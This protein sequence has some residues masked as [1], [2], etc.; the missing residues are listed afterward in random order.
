MGVGIF[1]S[2]FSKEKG[3]G[4][5]YFN[6]ILSQMLWCLPVIPAPQNLEAKGSQIQG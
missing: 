5:H 2:K 3:G 6:I 1:F 4:E